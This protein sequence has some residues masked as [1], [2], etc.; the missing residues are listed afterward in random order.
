MPTRTLQGAR[1]SA[2][3]FQSGVE[4]CFRNMLHALKEYLEYFSVYAPTE[5]QIFIELR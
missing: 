2:A 3:N 1:K 4:Q 5:E